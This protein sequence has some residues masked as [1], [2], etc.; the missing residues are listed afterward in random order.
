MGFILLITAYE[1]DL[2]VDDG[3]GGVLLDGR[4]VEVV[5]RTGLWSFRPPPSALLL[6][7]RYVRTVVRWGQRFGKRKINKEK[8]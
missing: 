4:R 8:G 1:A 6:R 5:C 7:H 2:Q 3:A